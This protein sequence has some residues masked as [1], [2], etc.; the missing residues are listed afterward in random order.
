MK[1]RDAA[2]LLVGLAITVFALAAAALATETFIFY[3]PKWRAKFMESF[4]NYS[5]LSWHPLTIKLRFTGASDTAFIDIQYPS[6][7][8]LVKVEGNQQTVAREECHIVGF[9]FLRSCRKIY[10]TTYVFDTELNLSGTPHNITIYTG[11]DRIVL[12]FQ[13]K[14]I[15]VD[16]EEAKDLISMVESVQNAF[17]AATLLFLVLGLLLIAG[18]LVKRR[19][20]HAPLVHSS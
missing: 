17:N 15:I 13:G 19:G 11:Y 1:N 8:E 10:Y 7:E 6:R 4:V 5:I 9:P 16:S 20:K 12:R 3:G 2:V 14:S 18:F